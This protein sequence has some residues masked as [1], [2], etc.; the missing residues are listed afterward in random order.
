MTVGWI[1]E[2]PSHWV[3]DSFSATILRLNMAALNC[4]VWDR[5]SLFSECKLEWNWPTPFHVV[6]SLRF[7]FMSAATSCATVLMHEGNVAFQCILT[8]IYRSHK[9][10]GSPVSIINSW[11]L[12]SHGFLPG[13]TMN[14]SNYLERPPLSCFI[15]VSVALSMKSKQARLASI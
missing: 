11:R 2:I 1:A 3:Q 9:F 8:H 4:L 13:G 6:F 15:W 7:L 12:N 14:S 10:W 5:F